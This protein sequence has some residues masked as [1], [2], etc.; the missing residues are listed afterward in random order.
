MVAAEP[1]M[2]HA[3][4]PR[5]ARTVPVSHIGNRVAPLRFLAFAAICSV[6]AAAL[7][8]MLGWRHGFMIGFDLAAA[9]FLLSCISLFGSEAERMRTIAERNDA[10]RTMLLVLTGAVSLAILTAIASELMQRGKA[11]L[12]TI[13][14]ILVTLALSWLFS[15]MIY[16]LHYAHMFYI[17]DGEGRDSGGLAIPGTSEP[18]YWDFVYF[19]VCLGMTFQTSDVSLTDR[20]F[21]RVV[22]G[23]CLAAFVFNLGILA[24]TINVLGSG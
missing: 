7:V 1:R 5:Q 16:A 19:A 18:D 2:G 22:T 6:A 12:P 21:R 3:I 24:F 9:I 8:P 13:I 11:E 20:R 23:H 4:M 15:N 14:L 17:A 10:N